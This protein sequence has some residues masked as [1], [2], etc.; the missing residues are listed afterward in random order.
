MKILELKNRISEINSLD[1]WQ[2][3]DDTESVHFKLDH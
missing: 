1:K 3:V 2:K